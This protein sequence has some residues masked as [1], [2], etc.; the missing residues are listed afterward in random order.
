M[1]VYHPSAVYFHRVPFELSSLLD[2]LRAAPRPG[3]PLT[4]TI[5]ASLFAAVPKVYLPSIKHTEPTLV[6]LELNS[7]EISRDCLDERP[8][9]SWPQI[10]CRLV[11]G[12]V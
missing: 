10:T 9:N 5:A 11:T 6:R 1:S 8:F 4:P 7:Q 12:H 2:A 3:T